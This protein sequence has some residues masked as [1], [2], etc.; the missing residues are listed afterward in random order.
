[1]Q[2]RKSVVLAIAVAVIALGTVQSTRGQ[3]RVLGPAISAV[4]PQAPSRSATAQVLTITGVNLWAGLSLTV[5]EPDGRKVYYTGVAIQERR[6]TSFKVSVVLASTGAYT[7][8]VTNPDGAT[9]DPFVLKGTSA[10]P[11]VPAR[12]SP[13]ID[14]VLPEQ[15]TRD[16]QPQTLAVTGNYFASGLSVSVTDPTGTVYVI[17]GA[18]LGT[19]TA[20]SFTMSLAIEMTGEYG[21]MVTNPSG[22]SSNTVMIKAVAQRR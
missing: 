21:V 15:A 5:V 17:K 14:R 6:D 2:T 11:P 13:K 4:A 12:R 22:E 18:A 19:V 10:E 9:S 16:P 3:T 20:T 1:M 8:I 7:L